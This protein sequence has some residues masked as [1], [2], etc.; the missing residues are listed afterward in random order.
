MQPASQAT[1]QQTLSVQNPDPHS[2]ALSHTAPLGLGPQL[3]LTHKTPL[4][5]SLL[6]LQVVTHAFVAGSQLKGAQIVAGP[7]LQCPWPS[8]T[9][10]LVTDAPSQV[11]DLQVVPAGYLRQC[12]WPSQLPSSPQLEAG[13][14]AQAVDCSCAP[15]ATNEQSPGA[16]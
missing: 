12:P 4:V 3:P 11:P 5:Q 8:Q 6:D 1:L 10:T 2:L 7:D 14:A 9:L 16:L 15:F 13:D